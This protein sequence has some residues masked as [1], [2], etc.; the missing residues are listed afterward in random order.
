M[1][2]CN[3][4]LNMWSPLTSV[5][6][7]K[8]LNLPPK[9][10]FSTR[11]RLYCLWRLWSNCPSRTLARPYAKKTKTCWGSS[12]ADLLP[13]LLRKLTCTTGLRRLKTKNTWSN[14]SPIWTQW[15]D[16]IECHHS[17]SST[18]KSWARSLRIFP[19]IACSASFRSSA[20]CPYL[21][22]IV[23][24]LWEA[25]PKVTPILVD[26]SN[27]WK[28]RTALNCSLF[29]SLGQWYIWALKELQRDFS[30]REYSRRQPR[31]WEA[32]SRSWVFMSSP[33]NAE[34]AKQAKKSTI[35]TSFSLRLQLWKPNREKKRTQDNRLKGPWLITKMGLEKI[36]NNTDWN[37][38]TYWLQRELS[39][40]SW[41]I[42]FDLIKRGK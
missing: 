26:T 27:S 14:H 39:R 30:W 35:S 10:R 8:L 40:L 1:V 25:H 6:G 24:S 15:S 16:F 11:E 20:A 28:A 32:T 42:S 41:Q 21:T 22:V 33:P 9:E 2:V 29:Q 34:T 3:P 13:L 7:K 12:F 38:T 4:E 36:F 23:S 37:I 5:S 19:R 18:W 17:L 31:T